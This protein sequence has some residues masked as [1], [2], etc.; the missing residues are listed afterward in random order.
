MI[1]YETYCRIHDARKREGL[2]IVQVA[3]KL[4]LHPETVSKWL[5]VGRF[6]QRQQ[7]RRASHL[8]PY[9]G[10]IVR[11]L[12]AAHPL[13]AQQIFQRLREEGYRGGRTILKDYVRRV[14]PPQQKSFLK[15][16][17]APG[18]CAQVDWGEYGT[19]GVGSTKR[20]LSFFVMVL[21]YS[22]QMY[23][24]FTVSQTM[25]HF[26]AC[27]EHAFEVLGVPAKIMV[28]NLKSGLD[29]LSWTGSCLNLQCLCGV[30]SPLEVHG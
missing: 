28:D 17:F 22:R 8:D 5:R 18:E 11:W 13:S 6:C 29:P 20:R 1:D 27:H 16:A 3:R 23:L 21:C 15:L 24:E 12:E 19:I 10:L 30:E 26:L 7:L 14:R 9:K 2:N 4:A 25:E